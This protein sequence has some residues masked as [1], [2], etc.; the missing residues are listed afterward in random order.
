VTS[1]NRRRDSG[2]ARAGALL[3][4][5][6]AGAFARAAAAGERH[7]LALMAARRA[8]ARSR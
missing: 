2:G 7:R 5:A 3:Q 6:I 4:I 1:G 8:A